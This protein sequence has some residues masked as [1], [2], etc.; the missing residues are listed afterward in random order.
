MNLKNI[1]L[2]EISQ[3]QKTK[4]VWSYLHEVPIVVESIKTE[5]KMMVVGAGVRDGRMGSCR[6]MVTEFQFCN[7]KRVL[8]IGCTTM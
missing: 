6:F 8:E 5:S 4:T 1:M 7:M 2:R 3:S